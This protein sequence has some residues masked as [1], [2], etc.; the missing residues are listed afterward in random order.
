[1]TSHNYLPQSKHRQ[2]GFTLVELIM[3]IVILGAIGG[4]VAVFMKGPIDAYF[5]SARRAA[6]SDVADTAVRRIARDIH[7]ALPNSLRPTNNNQCIEF[8]PT[9]TGGRY[10]AATNSSGAGDIL[11]FNTADGSFDMLGTNS[12]PT[13]QAIRVGDFIAVYNLGI[14]GSDAYAQNN[15][16]RV[17]SVATGSL[18]NETK[19]NL[20]TPTQFPLASDKNNRFHVIPVEEQVVAYVC[21]GTQKLRRTVRTLAQAQA[22]GQCAATGD[23]MATNVSACNFVYNGSDLQRNALVQLS[24]TLTDTGGESVTLYHEVHTDNTP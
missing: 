19:I 22:G 15:T 11:D 20:T 23:I 21:D 2:S 17:S 13:D 4:T 8:I 3:V 14:T 6:L 24:I 5:A 1:M 7:K 9:R 16:A 12:A 10:R 18:S